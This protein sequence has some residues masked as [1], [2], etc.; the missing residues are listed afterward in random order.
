[1]PRAVAPAG[2]PV[3]PSGRSRRSSKADDADDLY[4]VDRHDVAPQ[5]TVKMG[6]VRHECRLL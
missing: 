1:M 2:G 6:R 3:N 5:I 4:L